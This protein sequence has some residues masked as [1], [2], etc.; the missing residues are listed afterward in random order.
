VAL[1]PKFA[2]A[3]AA[4]AEVLTKDN[5]DW[6]RVFSQTEPTQP[7][8]ELNLQNWA[9]VWAQARAAAHAAAEQAI[10]L[11]PNLADS[12]AAMAQVLVWLDWDWVAAD[13][14]VK[15]A[16]E[17][18]P[19][20]AR[21]M[22]LASNLAVDLGHVAE[23]LELARRAEALDPLGHASNTIFWAQYA[24]GSARE[25]QVTQ[26]RAIELYPQATGAHFRMGLILLAL[27]EPESALSE[28]ERERVATFREVGRPLALDAL[29]RH[30]EA[31]HVMAITEQKYGSGMAYQIAYLYASRKDFDRAF[32]WLERAYQQ[33]DGGLADLKTDP[34]FKNLRQD[35][36]FAALL[37]KMRFPE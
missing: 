25:A 24:E 29:G 30:S 3:W 6:T 21:V 10:Q 4:L 20:N 27:S 32:H 28:F 5:V 16:L 17:L 12:H 37:R 9:A 34:M 15:T 23:G 7:G 11:G 36:R 8:G 26:R 22:L 2:L 18:E 35:P 1:D 19:G 13:A 33:K 14:Q 31:D